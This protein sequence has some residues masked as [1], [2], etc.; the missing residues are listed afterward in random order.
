MT[1]A[2]NKNLDTIIAK[3]EALQADIAR[4]TQSETDALAAAKKRLMQIY[5]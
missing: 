4:P 5:T 1:S 2:Q 3:I